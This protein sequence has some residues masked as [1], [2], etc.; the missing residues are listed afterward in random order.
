APDL[1]RLV[2]YYLAEGS[3]EDRR[4]VFSFHEKEQNYRNDV[5]RIVRRNFDLRG[6]ETKETGLG[7][8]V[9]YDS[10]VLARVFGSLGK[11]CDRKRVPPVFMTAPKAVREELVRGLWRGDGHREFHRNYFGIVTTSPHLAY[12]MQESLAGRG[13]AAGLPA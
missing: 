10:A 13:I 4:L 6:Y 1:G 7:S 8:N 9:R 5:R 2:G 3:A 12:Q 11:K